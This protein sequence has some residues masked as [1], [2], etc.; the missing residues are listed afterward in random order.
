MIGTIL[1]VA[2]TGGAAMMVEQITVFPSELK[3]QISQ[4]MAA[5]LEVV[6]TQVVSDTIQENGVYE[7]EAVRIYEASR[8]NAFIITLMFMAFSAF[9]AYLLARRL[10]VV[11]A[12]AEEEA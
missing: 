4:D 1:V 12:V 6:S 9:V 10:P 3:Q 5:S 8:Q 7:A 2:L 11:K